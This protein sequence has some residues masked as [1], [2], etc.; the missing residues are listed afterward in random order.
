MTQSVN[1]KTGANFKNPDDVLILRGQ[2][3]S[4]VDKNKS[5]SASS[6][7]GISLLDISQSHHFTVTIEGFTTYKTPDN[8]FSQFLPVKSMNYNYLSY[9]NMSIPLSIFGDFPLLNK[10]RVTTIT[11]AC[12]DL[13]DNKLEHELK[14]W[15]NDCFPKGRYVAYMED[16]VRKL[17]YRGYDVK[18]K[19]TLKR[20]IFVIPTGN[21]G[22]SRDYSANDAKIITFSLV[23]V[24]D[25][26]T[27]ATGS[28]KVVLPG[29]KIFDV[30]K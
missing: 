19:E 11:L 4:V 15:E 28:G 27:C 12:Y 7:A 17:I 18:G 9:E 8:N 30:L 25:G 21:V 5:K 1:Q 14:A 6:V 2:A 26:S 13:D 20:E 23:C 22:V 24:G 16:I 3:T 29:Q 10:K